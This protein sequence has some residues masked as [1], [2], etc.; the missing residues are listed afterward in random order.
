MYTDRPEQL[1]AEKVTVRTGPADTTTGQKTSSVAPPSTA[2]SAASKAT[3]SDGAKAEQLTADD[4]A[5]RC[6]DA[7]RRYEVA[8]NSSRLY[9][10][11]P[12]GERRYLSPEE[13]NAARIN[14]KQT[15]DTFC[16]G[17]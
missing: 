11:A 4:L 1:P 7:R 12:N 13:I 10:Q 6:A 3:P 2:R 16:G 15:M 14:A 8:M 9:E 17:Q 5:Q